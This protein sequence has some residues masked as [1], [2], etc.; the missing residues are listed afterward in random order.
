MIL[1]KLT[2]D[3]AAQDILTDY[4]YRGLQDINQALQYASS[5]PEEHEYVLEEA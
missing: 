3:I 1:G 2:S 5:L 4:P